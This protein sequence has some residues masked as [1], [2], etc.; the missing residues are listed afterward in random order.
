MGYHLVLM[1]LQCYDIHKAKLKEIL[2]ST[3]LY[4]CY[5][6]DLGLSMYL[7]LV[8]IMVMQYGSYMVK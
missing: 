6:L 3:L 1:M 8:Q 4:C 2:K 5:V 7:S